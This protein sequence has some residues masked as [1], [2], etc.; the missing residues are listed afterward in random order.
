[1]LYH[2]HM[3]TYYA[4]LKIMFSKIKSDTFKEYLITLHMTHTMGKPGTGFV[5]TQHDSGCA[6]SKY[7]YTRA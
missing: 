3:L 2:H 5:Y 4:G 6:K 1:M 7:N